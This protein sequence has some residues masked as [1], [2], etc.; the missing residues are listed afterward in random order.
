[1]ENDETI[2]SAEMLGDGTIVLRL[3]AVS[4]SGDLGDAVI[5]Y[6]SHGPGWSEI[7]RHVGGLEPGM[8][9]HVPPWR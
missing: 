6:P 8:Q 5:R 4:G 1:M 9:K 2:G 3:R 7:V